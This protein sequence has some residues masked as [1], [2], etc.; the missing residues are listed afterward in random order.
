MGEPA[1]ESGQQDQQLDRYQDINLFCQFVFREKAHMIAS[2]FGCFLFCII[3][4]SIE[5]KSKIREE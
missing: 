4:I 1:Q 5:E 2:C 3:I